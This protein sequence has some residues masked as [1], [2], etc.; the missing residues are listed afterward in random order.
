MNKKILLLFLVCLVVSVGA[1]NKKE[2]EE[3]TIEDYME[4]SK[5][6][7][8]LYEESESKVGGLEQALVAYGLT[9]KQITNISG[10]LIMPDGNRKYL[11]INGFVDLGKQINVEPYSRTPNQ[12]MVYIND[13]VALK[14]TNN[15]VMQYKEDGLILEHNS[16]LYG[17]IQSYNY[18]GVEDSVSCY[19]AILVPYVE[20]L[21]FKKFD[22][23]VLFLGESRAGYTAE[24][25]IKVDNI[26]EGG[27]GDGE[28]EDYIY[29]IG[30]TIV[31]GK[32]TVY[33]FF[34]KQSES[35]DAIKELVSNT[36]G[37]ISFNG[38]GLNIE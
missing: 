32:I 11:S 17:E 3:P 24:L 38:V 21:G 2:K 28:L 23:K 27:A 18:A 4:L 5:Y 13:V 19:S 22:V 30:I 35:S 6:Y 16:G 8:E 7:K 33:K 26:S 20:E 25:N 34:Y 36:V 15:W 14:S 31:K 37:N 9:D 1:C 29:N 12:A 10:N